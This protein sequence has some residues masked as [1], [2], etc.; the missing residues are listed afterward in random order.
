MDLQ[1]SQAIE[2][3]RNTLVYKRNKTD[4]VEMMM[5]ND[6]IRLMVALKFGGFSRLGLTP[7]GGLP[8][9]PSRS[10]RISAA[11]CSEDD[12]GT[13]SIENST[14]QRLRCLAGR[15]MNLMECRRRGGLR[16]GISPHSLPHS[17]WKI[18][19]GFTNQ[20]PM[21]TVEFEYELHR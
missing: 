17:L 3:I 4:T 5:H 15:A 6:R 18:T 2:R 7:S 16:P 14:G 1:S 13:I 10:A 12:E 8:A 20:R 11:I 9:G 21:E 19:H